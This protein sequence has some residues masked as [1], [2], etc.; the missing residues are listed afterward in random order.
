MNPK[1]VKELLETLTEEFDLHVSFF[2]LG[3]LIISEDDAK[4]S[5]ERLEDVAQQWMELERDE[6]PK[7]VKEWFE[8]MNE[9]VGLHKNHRNHSI[10][11]G[12]TVSEI[13][14]EVEK[15]ALDA[16]RIPEVRDILK[17][18]IAERELPFEI[19]Y[20]GFNII[21][22]TDDVRN[23]NDGE[24]LELKSLLEKENLA[25]QVHHSGFNIERSEAGSPDILFPRVQELTSRLQDSLESH[26][27]K[28][29]L[30]QNGFTLE[31]KQ[32]DE[33][34]VVEAKELAIRL[35]F[36]SGIEYSAGGYGMG[37]EKDVKPGWTNEINWNSVTLFTKNPY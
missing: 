36:M 34:H 31:K 13:Y 33:V 10:S 35:Q 22:L 28:T 1:D 11:I 12:K 17:A 27:L 37:P 32:E 16:E 9:S 29:Y 15:Q 30:L 7:H 21:V 6:Y 24:M 4:V 25:V 3:P 23:Y 8:K 19:Y 20:R 5:R 18:L 14:G 2:N 26:G